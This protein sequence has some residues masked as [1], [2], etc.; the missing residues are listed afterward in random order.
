MHA[1]MGIISGPI[2]AGKSYLACRKGHS[3]RYFQSS[4]L[5]QKL[6]M[7]HADGSYPKFLETLA[8]TL[9][10][11]LDDWLRNPLS[12]SKTLDLLEMMDG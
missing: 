10:L 8:K 9:L 3:V 1:I 12:E 6:V 5:L 2:G 4:R 11:I 7:S